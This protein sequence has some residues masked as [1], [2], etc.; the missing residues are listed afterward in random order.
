MSSKAWP[1]INLMRKQR[2]TPPQFSRM[3]IMTTKLAML[4]MLSSLC[5]ACCGGSN[6]T[7]TIY[8]VAPQSKP[9]QFAR[10]LSVISQTHGLQPKVGVAPDGNGHTFVVIRGMGHWRMLW[11]TNVALTGQEDARLCGRYRGVHPDPAQFSI[12]IEPLVPFTDGESTKKLI[13]A[14]GSDLIA[15]GYTVRNKGIL[16]SPL[17][18]TQGSA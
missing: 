16:C 8:V 10:D 12:W 15:R 7:I 5:L 1:K 11:S 17:S 2:P 9:G 18:R 13:G 3:L 14:I 4:A 6:S